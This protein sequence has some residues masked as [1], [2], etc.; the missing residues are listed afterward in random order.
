MVAHLAGIVFGHHT[1][2]E[3]GWIR[4]I[5]LVPLAQLATQMDSPSKKKHTGYRNKLILKKCQEFNQSSR[6]CKNL[7]KLQVRK[8]Q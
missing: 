5:P 3:V 6:L 8:A 2:Y 7:H 1:N 4:D